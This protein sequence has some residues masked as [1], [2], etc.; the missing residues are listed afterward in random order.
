MN[1]GKTLVHLSLALLLASPTSLFAGPIV[2]GDAPP[3]Y[4][5]T[6]TDGDKIRLSDNKG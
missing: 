1:I 4:L 2:V 6:S 3:D 5:G